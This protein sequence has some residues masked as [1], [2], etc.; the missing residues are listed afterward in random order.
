MAI[1]QESTYAVRPLPLI[2][3]FEEGTPK[4]SIGCKCMIHWEVCDKRQ[5]RKQSVIRSVEK[6]REQSDVA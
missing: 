6:I 4:N 5:K 2:E 1:A 3:A